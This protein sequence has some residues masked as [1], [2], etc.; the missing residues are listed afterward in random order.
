MEKLNITYYTSGEVLE[1]LY[2]N[3]RDEIHRK[4]GPARIMFHKNGSVSHEF[5]FENDLIHRIDGPAYIAYDSF[6]NIFS[7]IF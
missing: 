2:V 1:H 7:V 6:G 3:E 4:S 5:Y